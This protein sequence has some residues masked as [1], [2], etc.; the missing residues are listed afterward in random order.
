[1][2]LGGLT[3]VSINYY[4]TYAESQN[5]YSPGFDGGAPDLIVDTPPA[6]GE[7]PLFRQL[8][9]G[10]I[11]AITIESGGSGYDSV[12][13]QASV[14]LGPHLLKVSDVNSQYYGR[15]F[16]ISDNNRS[17]LTLDDS[18]LESGETIQTILLQALLLKLC[19]LQH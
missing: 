2:S 1:M 9:G 3:S 4:G 7:K 15:V 10:A 16:L 5:G 8:F 13:S 17:R 12:I 19:V 6:A 11:T 18:R 14:L